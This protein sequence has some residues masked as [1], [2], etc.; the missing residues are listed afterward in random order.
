MSKHCAL[1]MQ[2][3]E[4]DEP[5]ILTIGGYGTPR[6]LCEDCASDIDTARMDRNYDNIIAA[7][8]RV[9]KKI[10]AANTADDTVSMNTVKEIFTS[11]NDRAEKIKDGTYDFSLDD[12]QHEE[13][14]ELT[15]E[16]AETEEDRELDRRDEEKQKRFDKIYGWVAAAVIIA[17]LG[18]VVYKYL[19]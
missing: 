19:F 15:E 2:E 13:E 1:C 12:E 9:A 6:Y 10:S 5:D 14:F 17:A 16:Y 8:D 18:F 3:V 4:S 7:M 11:A